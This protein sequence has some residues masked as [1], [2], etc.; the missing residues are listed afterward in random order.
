[1]L[2]RLVPLETTCLQVKSV[3]CLVFQGIGSYFIFSDLNQELNADVGNAKA[4]V[5]LYLAGV[6]AGKRRNEHPH[7]AETQLSTYR[8]FRPSRTRNA[9][10]Y[11][12]RK[13][14]VAASKHERA[15]S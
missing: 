9:N 6:L 1:M 12:H 14:A 4:G 3:F 15:C 2:R 10:P 11:P 7:L 8:K 13:L 5:S